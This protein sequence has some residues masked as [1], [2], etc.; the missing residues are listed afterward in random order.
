MHICLLMSA[1]PT[2]GNICQ[3]VYSYF[4]KHCDIYFDLFHS[5]LSYPI[6][7]ILFYLS[8]TILLFFFFRAITDQLVRFYDPGMGHRLEFKKHCSDVLPGNK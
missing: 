3:T 1:H 2:K 4:M 8:L 7:R 6:L 5:V